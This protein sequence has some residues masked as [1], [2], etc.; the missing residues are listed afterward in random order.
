MNKKKRM[1]E[2]SVF[3]EKESGYVV[4]INREE[5]TW[6][7]ISEN[8]Y[9]DICQHIDN[10][11]E[12]DIKYN[13]LLNVLEKYRILVTE[14]ESR[15]LENITVMLTN[16]CNLKCRHCCASE[17]T[18]KS[19][20]SVNLIDRVIDMKPEQITISGGEPLLHENIKDILAHIRKNYSGLL[21]IA[22]NGTLVEKY[23]DLIIKYVDKVEISLDG[24]TAEG[25]ARYRGS[26]V[27]EKVLES[28]KALRKNNIRVAIS[29]V[30]YDS[31]EKEEFQRLNELYGTVP[32][33]RELHIN[34]RVLENIEYI[35]PGGRRAYI[36]YIKSAIKNSENILKLRTCG[37]V[38]Y[39]LF[40]DSEGY[41]YPCGGMAEDALRC[42]NI[43]DLETTEQIIKHPEICYEK[44]I[45]KVLSWE[46]FSRCRECNVRSFCWSCIGDILSRAAID[47]VFEAYCESNRKKWMKYIWNKE[48]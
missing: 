43:M 27:F 2:T 24:V 8:V 42:G 47:E 30:S 31:H 23:L 28:V 44:I 48:K 5:G 9:N 19:D 11:V 18:T 20:I 14:Y 39:Q 40:I 32:I 22:T 10:G 38:S 3:I 34:K 12:F 37:A 41:I 21:A 25:T 36:E 4:L 29:M 13:E 6:L 15:H 7:R 46:K 35:I 16:R 45:E 1:F 33:L 17:I 26:S